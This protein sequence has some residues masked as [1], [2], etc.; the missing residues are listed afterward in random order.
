MNDYFYAKT[1]IVV[2][3]G[4]HGEYACRSFSP[5]VQSVLRY[6][7]KIC[8]KQQDKNGEMIRRRCKE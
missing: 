2:P 8:A 4:S 6:I 1:E 7:Y 5:D 3:R